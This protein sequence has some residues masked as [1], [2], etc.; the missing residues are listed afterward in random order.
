MIYHLDV[1]DIEPGRWIAWVF[2]LH[3]CFSRSTTPEK[4]VEAAPQAI[5]DF[6]MWR[7]GYR[8]QQP[9]QPETISISERVNSIDRGEYRIN[10]FFE[11]DRLPLTDD[12]VGQISLLLSYAR[13]DLNDLIQ[14]IPQEYLN[15]TIPGERFGSLNGILSHIAIAE[16]WFFDSMKL[17][18]AY[19]QLSGDP[20]VD[21]NSTRENT[22]TLMPSLTDR[23]DVV[24]R[25]EEK[26]SVRKILRKTIWHEIVHT[27]HIRKRLSELDTD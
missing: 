15:C 27:R 11:H 22:L 7:N 16:W 5:A 26:W 14:K 25:R 21:L 20:R 4:A 6:L 13:N 19:D 12:D 9:L 24:L 10:A 18:F 23:S 1:T 2:E 8:D 3:G 17:G